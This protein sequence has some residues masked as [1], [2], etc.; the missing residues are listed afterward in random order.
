MKV[1]PW[2]RA[3]ATCRRAAIVAMVATASWGATAAWANPTTPHLN[4]PNLSDRAVSQNNKGFSPPDRGA[5]SSTSDGGTRGCP[6]ASVDGATVK[7]LNVLTLTEHLPLTLEE[8]PTFF[9]Y[10][11]PGLGTSV[12]FSLFQFDPK[13]N[14]DTQAIYDVELAV[15]PE[16]G[17]VSHRLPQNRQYQLQEGQM[18]HWYVVVACEGTGLSE[19][20]FAD[21]FIERID[22]NQVPIDLNARLGMLVESDRLAVSNVYAEAGVWHEALLYLARARDADPHNPALQERWVDLLKAA[23][24]EQYSEERVIFNP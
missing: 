21:G 16:G 5:P 1:S 12:Q 15:P 8:Y 11:P 18:Y 23:N 4:R 7:S 3:I 17:I 6:I 20:A 13:T 10:I 19:Y 9:W 24:L 22:S 14:T 2:M